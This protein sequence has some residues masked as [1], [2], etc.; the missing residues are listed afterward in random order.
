[1]HSSYSIAEEH[2]LAEERSALYQERIALQKEKADWERVHRLRAPRRYRML[3]WLVDVWIAG[4]AAN[5][6]AWML[7]MLSISTWYWICYGLFV[8]VFTKQFGQSLGKMAFELR[9]TSEQH[10]DLTWT[11][12]MLRETIGRLITVLTGIGFIFPFLN[13]KHRAIHDLM[14]A[15]YVQ[16]VDTVA[17]RK[18]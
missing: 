2:A 13:D 7:P 1:M 16:T 14:A 10:N 18:G 11:T 17:P 3:A 8:I 12:V 15:T 9:V 5:L 4:I 6:L